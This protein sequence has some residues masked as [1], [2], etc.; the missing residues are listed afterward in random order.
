MFSGN[1]NQIKNLFYK[2]FFVTRVSKNLYNK[3]NVYKIFYKT[4][5]R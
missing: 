2:R 4:V 3:I 1:Y 5:Q